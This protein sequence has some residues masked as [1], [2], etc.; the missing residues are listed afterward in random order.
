MPR[1]GAKSYAVGQASCKRLAS[2]LQS[3]CR[4]RPHRLPI[5]QWPPVGRIF[6][7]RLD[8]TAAVTRQLPLRAHRCA[9]ARQGWGQNPVV[10]GD[11]AAAPAEIVDLADPG[12]I[13]P[14]DTKVGR[15]VR[16]A[17][18]KKCRRGGEQSKAP[19]L[20]SCSPVVVQSGL[21]C[22]GR[23]A[24]L[25]GRPGK[26]FRKGFTPSIPPRLRDDDQQYKQAVNDRPARRGSTVRR[27]ALSDR[28]PRA[29]CSRT[30]RTAVSIAPAT[31]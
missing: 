17:C 14:D 11:R 18:D 28:H 12:E 30:V 5:N 3:S 15:R 20:H 29:A 7:E 27:H 19:M 10:G 6:M 8:R 24:T 2:A 4:M 1:Y 26:L 9:E 25:T 21:R 16:G 13:P 23:I 22:R 31:V